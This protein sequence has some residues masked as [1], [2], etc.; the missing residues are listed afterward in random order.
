MGNASVAFLGFAHVEAAEVLL[1][2]TQ[3]SVGHPSRAVLYAD[4]KGDSHALLDKE[5]AEVLLVTQKSGG[6][7]SGAALNAGLKGDGPLLLG[8]G[9]LCAVKQ[10]HTC[11]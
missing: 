10:Q 5:A 6:R 4:L 7:P 1:G 8:I 9:S 11:E 3:K 2:Y